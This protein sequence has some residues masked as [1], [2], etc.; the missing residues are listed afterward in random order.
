M[1]SMTRSELIENLQGQLAQ[2]TRAQIE[3]G[4]FAV[5]QL[6]TAAL[7]RGERVEIRGFGVFSIRAIQARVARNPR[8]GETVNVSLTKKVHFKPGKELRQRVNH[9]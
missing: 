8:T 2:F 1:A 7:C 3:A 4:V 5:I 9:E 6:L